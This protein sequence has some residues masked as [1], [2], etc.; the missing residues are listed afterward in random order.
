MKKAKVKGKIYKVTA[1]AWDMGVFKNQLI[2]SRILIVKNKKGKTKS[3]R[4]NKFTYHST[5]K[6]K[7]LH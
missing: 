1:T 7:K 6:T 3:K 5:I 4:K 2:W